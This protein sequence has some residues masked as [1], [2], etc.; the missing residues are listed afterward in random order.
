MTAG[1][2][3]LRPGER[4]GVERLDDMRRPAAARA[5]SAA[6]S[7]AWGWLPVLALV[8]STGLLAVSG[9]YIIARN[10]G[11][12]P[13]PLYWIGIAMIAFVPMLRL[14]SGGA[15]RRERIGLV[16]LL[17]MC[18]YAMKIAY[19]PT[20][21]VFPDELQ[22]LRTAEDVLSTGRLFEENPILPISPL[23]PG[24]ENVTTALVSVSG[25][26]IFHAGILVIA[27]SRLTLALGIFL[28]F[29]QAT[30]SARAAG[31]AAFVYMGNPS[32]IHFGAQFVYESLALP[33]AVI[34]MYL[35][36]RRDDVDGRRRIAMTLVLL[37]AAGGVIVTHHA[38]AGVL[39]VI[40][41]IWAAVVAL[42]SRVR[43]IR[44]RLGPRGPG[45]ILGV[46]IVGWVAYVA[47][48]ALTY[49]GP[50]VGNSVQQVLR[51]LSGGLG[52]RQL[53][54]TTTGAAPPQ[55]EQ[56][57]SFA[58]V[59]VLLLGIPVGLFW[60]WNRHRGNAL[61]V[62]MAVLAA[63]YP[64]SLGLRLTSAGQDVAGRASPWLF[65]GIAPIIAIAIVETWRRQRP[66]M[67]ARTG[68][69]LGGSLILVAGLVAGFP[70]YS[71]LPGPY[72]VGGESRAFEEQGITAATWARDVLGRENR[73]VSDRTNRLLMGSYGEQHVVTSADTDARV[74]DLYTS[75]GVGVAEAEILRRG[76]VKYLVIDRR[77]SQALPA[78]GIY[79]ERGE[80]RRTVPLDPELLAKFDR[81]PAVS[82]VFD[83]GD[84]QIYDVER[85]TSAP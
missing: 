64:V 84:I 62:T 32:F 81:A 9:A 76:A 65:L 21:F 54:A 5:L 12:D 16:V 40:L 63:L 71:R 74:G 59:G 61:L 26:S 52:D 33:L 77:L 46:G 42:R 58:G 25:L 30:R 78:V 57:S 3:L 13:L 66:N 85:L 14:L 43:G 82:R 34:L 73:I 45:L 1:T 75:S 49:L 72:L 36:A 20:A 8:A 53:F 39:T 2:P 29:E 80:R 7:S 69:V 70:F 15:T 11:R 35:T 56:L 67:I 79:F 47:D 27:V 19:G 23:F 51:L 83:S 31:I 41:T 48:V 18:F 6:V 22:H 50:Y 55:W 24:V 44:E 28:L 68:L 60:V 10:A 37:I 17:T 4:V 38:S